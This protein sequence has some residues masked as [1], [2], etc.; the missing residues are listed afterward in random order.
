MPRLV[1]DLAPLEVAALPTRDAGE[2][3]L[4]VGLLDESVEG[5]LHVDVVVHREAVGDD[6]D[7]THVGIEEAVEPVE[8]RAAAPPRLDELVHG[9]HELDVG[10]GELFGV[11]RHGR[12]L[13]GGHRRFA[14]DDAP[15]AGPSSA[16]PGTAPTGP[17]AAGR[18][19][20]SPSPGGPR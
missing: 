13:S 14:A 16:T 7:L 20:R 12:D 2:L 8:Q 19:R 11:E 4:A 3:H 1:E 17:A 6:G 5:D 9:G 15:D 18:P 10:T